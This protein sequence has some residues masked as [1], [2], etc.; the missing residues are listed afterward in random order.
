MPL[1]LELPGRPDERVL[2]QLVAALLFE[3]TVE[4]R[5]S[6]SGEM[7]WALGDVAFR[8]RATRGPDHRCAM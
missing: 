5:L 7:N 2:R 8:C 1:P 4:H 3:G 6:P